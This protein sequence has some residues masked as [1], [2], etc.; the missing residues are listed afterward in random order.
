M[1]RDRVGAEKV[2]K[3]DS[4]LAPEY[5]E[6]FLEQH[7]ISW[8]AVERGAAVWP[9]SKGR[10]ALDMRKIEA[11]I[12]RED[13]VAWGWLNLREVGKF[14]NGLPWMLFPIQAEMARL[15][16][17]MVF[18]CGSA[19]GKTRDI[20]LQALWRADT[21]LL[22]GSVLVATNSA[23]TMETIWRELEFH[24]GNSRAMGLGV[25]ECGIGGGLRDSKQKPLRFMDFVNGF[26]F[27]MRLCGSDGEQFRGAHIDDLIMADEVA[28]WKNP[29][30]FSELWR[31]AN[32]P[33]CR[34][35]IY[36]TPDGDYS[37]PFY[38]LSARAIPIGSTASG[39]DRMKI[40]DLDDQERT[41]SEDLR[42]RKFWIPKTSLPEPLWS[43]SVAASERERHGGEDTPGW[44][45]NVLGKWG[46]PEYSA[47]PFY[48]LKTVLRHI[49]D[50]RIISCVAD[51]QSHL[52]S[53]VVAQSVAANQTEIFSAGDGKEEILHRDVMPDGAIDEICAEIGSWFSRTEPTDEIHF[54]WDVGVDADP[55]EILAVRKVHTADTFKCR[56]LFRAHIKRMGYTEQKKI[57]V[58]LDH[59]SHHLASWAVDAGNA[60]ADIVASIEEGRYCDRCRET[61]L[62]NGRVN[63][64][65]MASHVDEID[66]RTGEPLLNPDQLNADGKPKPY[67]ISN[68]EFSTRLIERMIQARDNEIAWDCGAGNP[69]IAGPQLL[70]NHWF[71]P[72]KKGGERFFRDKDDHSVE[73]RRQAY[74]SVVFAERESH[75]LLQPSTET[76]V[77][78]GE[79]RI[80]D[81]MLNGIGAISAF[82]EGSITSALGSEW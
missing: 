47:F 25:L 55:S 75:P 11:L 27:E 33:G 30:Q 64:F 6:T 52:V 82:R 20:I 46:D 49:P 43:E 51:T 53:L 42:F 68:K 48:R 21:S 34:L 40:L 73:A 54:G 18:E 74:L 22:G 3:S 36:S 57:F 28:K 39:A 15:S 9:T 24:V 4:R 61:I 37:C 66:Y 50:F 58:A 45:R 63:A 67:H 17:D 23:E 56:D 38:S 16:G 60:G 32:Q 80:Y 65:S 44:Q 1:S 19:V 79:K 26:H 72:G 41:E 31:A 62:F 69:R 8:S 12:A 29:S 59:A 35:R 81:S 10:V 13:P 5:I 2:K 76:C 7:G 70:V 71:K 77:V 14:R 78:G